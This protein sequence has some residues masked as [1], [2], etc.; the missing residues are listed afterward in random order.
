MGKLI[1]VLV[2]G[3]IAAVLVTLFFVGVFGPSGRYALTS[4]L[5]APDI[6]QQLNYNDMNPK[7]GAMDR[8]VFDEIQIQWYVP[9]PE[10]TTLSI[11]QFKQLYMAIVYDKNLASVNPTIERAFLP[12][13]AATISLMVRTESNAEWQKATK[14]FQQIQVALAGGYYRILLHEE[15]SSPQWVYFH[16]DDLLREL[17]EIHGK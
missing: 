5:L 2:S 3:V 12:N 8:F 11:A 9:K 15:S 7:T 14:D 17:S 1:A 13:P 4:V 16:N 10:K 6:L